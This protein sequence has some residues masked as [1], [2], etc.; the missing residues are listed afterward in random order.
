MSCWR[1]VA[2]AE[3]DMLSPERGGRD[4]L[5]GMVGSIMLDGMVTDS[6]R[7]LRREYVV[8]VARKRKVG[9]E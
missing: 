8:R 9:E 6:V 5:V 1:S 4:A 2:D 7:R 3:P